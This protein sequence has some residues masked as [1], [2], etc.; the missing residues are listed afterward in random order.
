MRLFVLVPRDMAE[1]ELRAE[2]EKFGDVEHVSL[3]KDKVTKERR[4]FAYIRFAKFS[5]AAEAYEECNAKYKAVFAEPKTAAPSAAAA[6]GTA[7]GAQAAAM[8]PLAGS[9]GGN[10]YNHHGQQQQHH[11]Q[12]QQHHGQQPLD[13]S[14]D[15]RSTSGRFNNHHHHQQ[16]HHDHD[17]GSYSSSGHN[18]RFDLHSA[19]G[20]SSSGAAVN[21]PTEASLSIVCS[22][23]L[24]Q[25]QLWRLFDIIPGLDFCQITGECSRT[26]NYAT[27]VYNNADAAAYARDKLHGLEYPPGERL[28]IKQ[29]I[30]IKPAVINQVVDPSMMGG[31]AGAG[32]T[33]GAGGTEGA[34]FPFDGSSAA[35]AAAAA[36]KKVF[37]SV[38]LPEPMQMADA[39]TAC[40]KRCFVVCVPEP[41]PVK[42][43]QNVFG[44]FGG[45][46]DVYMI[47]NKNCGYAKYATVESAQAAIDCLHRAEIWGVK[48]KVS[49]GCVCGE[50]F[51]G[52]KRI[53]VASDTGDGCRRTARRQTQALRG[54]V[55]RRRRR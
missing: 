14:A 30:D 5:H 49:V 41:L 29:S 52:S 19:F 26:S 24:N 32:V 21:G 23:A 55:K 6:T 1:E 40:A 7:M 47:P 16:Q 42:V 44:R 39:G 45:L 48:L 54:R 2:F 17:A 20:M 8:R 9:G 28:I 35:A 43:L 3:V 51:V 50:T 27:A 4:G 10:L 25:D 37:S 38:P 34:I 46:I 12:H 11:Q 33:G 13:Q 53:C 15:R 22:A 18:S 36:E 31:G